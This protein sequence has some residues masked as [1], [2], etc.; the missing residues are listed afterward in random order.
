M[1]RECKWKQT[2]RSPKFYTRNQAHTATQLYTHYFSWKGRGTKIPES[3]I[4]V[5]YTQNRNHEKEREYFILKLFLGLKTKIKELLTFGQLTLEGCV[6]VTPFPLHFP[7]FLNMIVESC[8]PV[9][10]TLLYFRHVGG[11]HLSLR[12]HRSKNRNCTPKAILKRLYPGAS[13]VPWL[14]LDDKNLDIELNS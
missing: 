5:Y 7:P 4:T 6:S 3:G 8:Y 13:S 14:N 9:P 12:C 11:R 10:V 1:D 2:V